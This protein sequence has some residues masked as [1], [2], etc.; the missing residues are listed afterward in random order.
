MNEL[1]DAELAHRFN[2]WWRGVFVDMK[3]KA[4]QFPPIA[5]G[6]ALLSGTGA[7]A[8][9]AMGCAFRHLESE[10][11]AERFSSRIGKAVKRQVRMG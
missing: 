2:W 5:I 4:K 3:S 1:S 11:G 6:V 9:S 10:K 8:W 7:E